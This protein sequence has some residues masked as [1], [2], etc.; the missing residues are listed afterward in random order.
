MPNLI[1]L[2]AEAGANYIG[3]DVNASLTITNSSTG[4]G[5]Q[6]DKLVATSSATVVAAELVGANRVVSTATATVPLVATRTVVGSSTVAMLALDIA[7]T[8]SGA[9]L[10]LRNQGFASCT[11]ILFTTGGV[12]GTG[13]VRVKYGDNYGWIPVLPD[14]AVTAVPRG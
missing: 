2:N 11:T 5:V 9:V 7:S 8:A 14:G 1:N 6:V 4:A 10:E 12:A 3:D 13:A